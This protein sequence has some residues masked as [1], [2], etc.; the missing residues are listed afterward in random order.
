VARAHAKSGHAT[1]LSGYVGTSGR[2]AEALADFAASYADQCERD[3]DAFMQAV[4]SG[5]L[6]AETEP[7]A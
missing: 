3:F 4:R 7:A 5:R 6:P 1:R 2:L